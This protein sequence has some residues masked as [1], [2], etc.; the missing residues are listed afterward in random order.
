MNHH[1]ASSFWKCYDN[2]PGTVQ[3]QADTHFALLKQNERHPSLH[4]KKIGDV[5]SVRASRHY[6]ALG[7]DV[8]DGILWI[9]IG[10]HSEYDRLVNRA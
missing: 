7:I 4:F 2:L 8:E 6:R 1:T 10:S 5:W 3:G 9:W